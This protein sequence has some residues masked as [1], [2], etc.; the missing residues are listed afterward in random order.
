MRFYFRLLLKLVILSAPPFVVAYSFHSSFFRIDKGVCTER[1]STNKA[2]NTS[3]LR[4]A[5]VMELAPSWSSLQ[6]TWRVWFSYSPPCS[7]YEELIVYSITADTVIDTS[8][9]CDG[10]I[11]INTCQHTSIWALCA[12]NCLKMQSLIACNRAQ[13]RAELICSSL[14][15]A[16]WCF[17]WVLPDVS[18]GALL[19]LT[20]RAIN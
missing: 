16:R 1:W 6:F 9:E 14:H 20:A 17:H 7:Y 5:L 18:G 2:A 4:A 3:W 13:R 15:C 11:K 12:C 19:D 10:T 8:V